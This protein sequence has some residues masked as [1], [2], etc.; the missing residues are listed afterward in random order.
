M[1]SEALVIAFVN[2]AS[3]ADAEKHPLSY[4]MPKSVH[5]AQKCG[6][7]TLP[8]TMHYMGEKYMSK[9]WGKSG[10]ILNPKEL[11]LTFWVPV[12]CKFSSKLSEK[13]DHRRG[14]RQ[15]DRHTHRHK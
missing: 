1:T 2:F 8:L 10:W 13:C 3:T 15:T 7:Q 6:V 11:D 9:N 14:D 5:G 12:R 4:Q